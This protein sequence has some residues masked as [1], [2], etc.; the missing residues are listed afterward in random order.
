MLYRKIVVI[1][2]RKIYASLS[3]FNM[4]ISHIKHQLFFFKKKKK[5][6]KQAKQRQE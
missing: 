3:L 1:I 5:K 4:Q 2:I 6:L